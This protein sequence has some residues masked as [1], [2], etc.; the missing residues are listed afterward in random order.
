MDT[1]KSTELIVF[2]KK[3]IAP[4]CGGSI[5]LSVLI[6]SY[7]TLPILSPFVLV[8]LALI[9]LGFYIRKGNTFF[10]A[11]AVFLLVGSLGIFRFH[12]EK[13]YREDVIKFIGESMNF[14]AVVRVVSPPDYR[15]NSTKIIVAH[16]F[17]RLLV[18]LPE[19]SAV[20]YGD[21]IDLKGTLSIPKPFETD[22]GRM[23]NY[24]GYLAKDRVFFELKYPKF[25]IY[26]NPESKSF[27]RYV[28]SIKNSI[29]NLIIQSHFADEQGLLLGILL[30]ERGGIAAHQ[31]AFIKTGT[32]HI[33]ALSGYNV[34]IISEAIA[35][36][37]IPLIGITGGLFFGAFGVIV[38]AVMTGLGATIVR[39]TLMGLLAFVSRMSGKQYNAGRAL[40]IAGTVMI[41]INPWIV[42]YDVSFQL[43]FIATLGLIYFTPVVSGWFKWIKNKG[44]HEIVSA[45][46]ATNITVMPF[47]AYVMGMVSLISIPA[48]ILIAPLVPLSMLFGSVSIFLYSLLPHLSI[49]FAKIS[50]SLLSMIIAIA[51]KGSS[52]PLSS[53]T[54]PAFSSMMVLVVYAFLV[55]MVVR[56]TRLNQ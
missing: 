21:Y 55:Y 25:S 29:R 48:N 33:V 4:I 36:I 27:L 1:Q 12:Q 16:S 39:A 7:Y 26:K 34:A 54:V 19:N 3:W 50:S 49:P 53:V 52:A 32:I 5:F 11:C 9:S 35:Y 40:L 47:V 37:L 15:E 14:D 41:I 44:L 56:N 13:E 38:F 2:L 43:S 20:E 6:E 30:G 24:S 23:F 10:V 46:V 42:V 51:E 45:T 22:Q 31:D 28:Y 17:A 18:T 8:L